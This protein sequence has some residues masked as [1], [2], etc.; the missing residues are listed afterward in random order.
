MYKNLSA[1]G[2]GISGRQSEMI[3]LALTYG[4]RGFDIDMERMVK[5]AQRN[6]LEFAA[7]FIESAASFANGF[8]IGGWNV[9][10]DW[11]AD[12]AEYQQGLNNLQEI[13]EIAAKVNALRCFTTISPAS[14]TLPYHENFERLRGRISQV[15]GVLA[16]HKI[17]LG[18]DFQPA[19]GERAGK[20]HEFIHDFEGLTTLC[21]TISEANVGIVLDTWNWFVGG[22]GM[23]Q[24]APLTNDKIIIV[25]LADVPGDADMATIKPR[26]RILPSDDG[27]ADCEGVLKLLI[28]K[29]YDGPVTPFPFSASFTGRTR[30]SIV[31]AAADCLDDIWVSIGLSKPK[32]ELVPVGVTAGDDD[33]DSDDDDDDSDADTNGQA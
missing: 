28:E 5:Q 26:Q 31:Q 16:K 1:V 14:D 4:F 10:I 21:G 11:D 6:S 29:E 27:L 18:L 22:G 7:R 12:D 8:S 9:G 3:E 25:R 23:D 32:S 13:V 15:A 30:E 24:I 19:P 17:R 20:A 33:D 2:L